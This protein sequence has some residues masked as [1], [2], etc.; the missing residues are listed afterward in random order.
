MS[1]ALL[2]DLLRSLSFAVLL[3]II[4]V[5]VRCATIEFYDAASLISEGVRI[6][7]RSFLLTALHPVLDVILLFLAYLLTSKLFQ[8]NIMISPY[9]LK[10]AMCYIAPYPVIL[11]LSGIYRTYWLPAS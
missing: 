5:V 4:F 8:R 9:T 1:A 7:R 2:S 6:P 3:G 11:S 10:Q